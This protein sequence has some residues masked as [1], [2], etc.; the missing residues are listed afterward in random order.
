MGSI[1]EKNQHVGPTEQQL[2]Q[3]LEAAKSNIHRCLCDDFD[4]PGVV[5]VLIEL[6]HDCN[7]IMNLFKTKLLYAR[8]DG[9][10]VNNKF[11]LIELELIEP[12]LFCQTKKHLSNSSISIVSSFNFKYLYEIC[13]I[14]R[15]QVYFP[16]SDY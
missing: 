3:K 12:F 10:M 2:L 5:Q 15:P 6:I 13:F 4:T 7:K 16:I 1:G 9:I 8:V 11:K 14:L